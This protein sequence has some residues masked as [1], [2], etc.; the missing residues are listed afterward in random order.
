MQKM[1]I[2][3]PPH[4]SMQQIVRFL[5]LKATSSVVTHIILDFVYFFNATDPPS[6][7]SNCMFFT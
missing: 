1:I 7:Y 6:K 2:I 3:I 4:F 5:Y